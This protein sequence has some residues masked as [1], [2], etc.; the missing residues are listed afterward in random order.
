M[1]YYIHVKIVDEGSNPLALLAFLNRPGDSK[2][3]DVTAN[4]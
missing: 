4:L 3:N 1:L 2:P